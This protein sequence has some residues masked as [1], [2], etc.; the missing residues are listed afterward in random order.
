MK[1][2]QPDPRP[3]S[4]EKPSTGK[5]GGVPI[6]THSLTGS[7]ATVGMPPRAKETGRGEGS[8]PETPAAQE[9]A[10]PEPRVED[11]GGILGPKP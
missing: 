8:A 1:D 6:G 4:Q 9:P 2:S 7:G 11:R 5:H 10:A 3:E